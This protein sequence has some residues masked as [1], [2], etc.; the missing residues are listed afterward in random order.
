MSNLIASLMLGLAVVS[1]NAAAVTIDFK[2]SALAMALDLAGSTLFCNLRALILPATSIYS[3][4]N[5]PKS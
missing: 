4:P 3:E 1:M 2:N 5:R